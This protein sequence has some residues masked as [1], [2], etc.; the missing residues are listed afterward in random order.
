LHFWRK[1]NVYNLEVFRA[2]L[3][4]YSINISKKEDESTID[5]NE[6]QNNDKN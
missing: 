3:N 1:G 4:G 6:E 2:I 5:I